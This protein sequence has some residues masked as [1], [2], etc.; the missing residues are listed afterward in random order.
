MAQ[1]SL[2]LISC[3]WCNQTNRIEEVTNCT[4]CGGPLPIPPS[5]GL[6]KEPPRAPRELPANY[7]KKRMNGDV[8]IIIGKIFVFAFFWTIIFP[9]IGYFLWKSGKERIQNKLKALEEGTPVIGKVVDVYKD[10]SVAMNGRNPWAMDYSFDTKKAQKGHGTISSWDPSV[11]EYKTG[12]K[13][14]VVYM[15]EDTDINSIW[16]PIKK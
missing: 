15:P 14:W 4:T 13:I 7:H 3:T 1:E 16:P 8:T 12:D 9:I 5:K 2:Q 10:T 11:S 6:A